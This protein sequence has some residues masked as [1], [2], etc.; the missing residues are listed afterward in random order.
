MTKN[1]KIVA[2]FDF[3]SICVQEDKFRYTDTTS[4]IG[5]H[6]PMFESIS[7]I[8]IEQPIFSCNSNPKALVEFFL[9]VFDGL[10]RHRKGQLK[11]KF[12]EIETCVK[13]KLNQIFSALNQRRCRKQP[14]LECEDGVSKKKNSRMCQHS[15]H[16]HKRTDF[17][18]C[19]IA[20]IDFATFFQSSASTARNITFFQ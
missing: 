9:D 13:N 15:L 5:Q 3:E 4:W 14:V 17:L 18:I 1:S 19:M 6:L 8:L 16:K 11:L 12:S 2:I 10:A 20:W 7:S